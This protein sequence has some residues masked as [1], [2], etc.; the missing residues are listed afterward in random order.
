MKLHNKSFFALIAVSAAFLLTVA[1]CKKS[2]SSSG[3]SQLSATISGSAWSSNTPVQGLY[4]TAGS[5]FELVGGYYKSGDT[6]ALAI[7][8]SRPF[9]LHTA[10]ASDTAGLDIG[11]IN[12]K[13]LTQYDGGPQAGH[14]VLTVNSWDSVNHKIS[15]TF[16]GVLYN[17]SGG[18]DSL[19]VTNGSFSTS[20]TVQ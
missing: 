3:G 6:T 18:T 15:G 16:S 7:Q 8:F 2:N 20:Y 19:I 1:S 13:T 4:V 10:F 5:I 12:A 17:T 11:Y 14:S 9:V